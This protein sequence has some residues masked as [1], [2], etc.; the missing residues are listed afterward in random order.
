VNHKPERRRSRYAP[1]KMGRT[2]ETAWEAS[3]SILAGALVGYYADKWLG[4]EPWLMIVF[5]V[6]GAAA[7]FRRLISLAQATSR[8]AQNERPPDD[9]ASP[10]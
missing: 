10:H 6:L 7:A 8:D 2:A 9:G 1:I 5:V 3:L 4:T